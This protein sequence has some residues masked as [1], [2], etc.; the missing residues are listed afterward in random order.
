MGEK[1]HTE[2]GSSTEVALV[3]GTRERFLA[4]FTLSF[5][6]GLGMTNLLGLTKTLNCHPE[7]K[8]GILPKLGR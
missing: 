1:I 4:E 2:F 8:R 5:A 7:R 3:S 6:E